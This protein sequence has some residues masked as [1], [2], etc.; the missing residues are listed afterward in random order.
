MKY[1]N[2]KLILPPDLL[3][4]LQEYLQGEY[5]YIPAKKEQR[6]AWGERSGY[7]Q[8]IDARNRKIVEVYN[9]GVAIEEIAKTFFLSVASIQKIIYR[10]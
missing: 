2:A 8:K 4:E 6:K 10:R 1:Q 9:D 7:R 5:L 3:A